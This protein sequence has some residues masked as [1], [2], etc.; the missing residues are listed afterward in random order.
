MKLLKIKNYYVCRGGIVI[1]GVGV[2]GMRFYEENLRLNPSG[3]N[4]ACR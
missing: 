3:A 1:M 4:G 2:V